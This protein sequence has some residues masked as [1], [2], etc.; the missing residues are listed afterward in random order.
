MKTIKIAVLSLFL[1]TLS[2]SKSSDDEVEIENTNIV[3]FW[4]LTDIIVDESNP[5]EE[6]LD[7]QELKEAL[8]DLDCNLISLDLRTD[9]TVTLEVFQVEQISNSA[10]SKISTFLCVDRQTQEGTWSFEEGTLTLMS[11][12]SLSDS[13]T[14]RFEGSRVAIVSSE[15]F[16]EL[17]DVASELVFEKLIEI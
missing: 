7:A 6:Q 8:G 10:N 5:V 4:V 15:P 9:N 3:G 12:S 14:V 17:G 16:G 11:S 13:S 2:C 1:I